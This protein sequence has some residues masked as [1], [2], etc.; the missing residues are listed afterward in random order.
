ME[1]GDGLHGGRAG[2]LVVGEE[3]F[4]D[5]LAVVGYAGDNGDGVLHELTGNGAEKMV[6]RKIHGGLF[7]E[8]VYVRLFCL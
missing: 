8:Y 7:S 5:V 6:R 4:L 3:P 2:F 1:I